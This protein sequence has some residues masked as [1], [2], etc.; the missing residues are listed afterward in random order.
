MT[1]WD[2]VWF[3]VITFAF[4][5]YLMILFSII[6]DLF[7][8][9]QL[10]GWW[11]ALWIVCLI[12]FP[13]ITALVYVIARG[14]GMAQRQAGTYEAARKEQEAY[15]RQVAGETSPADQIAKAKAMYDA[16]TINQQEYESLKKKAL[17]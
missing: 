4:V 16:G 5:A 1:F 10:N 12:V 15:I 7:R 3:I 6:T 9:H 17:V 2:V 11:K 8:D 14:K 13:L